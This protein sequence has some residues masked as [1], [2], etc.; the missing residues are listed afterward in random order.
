MG[1]AIYE[2]NLIVNG[3]SRVYHNLF[4]ESLLILDSRSPAD[5]QENCIIYQ[6]ENRMVYSLDMVF[7][8]FFTRISRRKSS[9]TGQY[10][11]WKI[12]KDAKNVPQQKLAQISRSVT[13]APYPLY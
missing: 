6:D 9:A 1:V 5:E 2:H 7:L 12:L 8:K 3:I 11:I 4:Y 10:E 13:R